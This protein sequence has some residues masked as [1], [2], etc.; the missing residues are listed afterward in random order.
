M[1]VFILIY[2][3][4]IKNR[5][6]F[7]IKDGYKLELQT[8]KTMKFFGSTE[9]D[10]AKIDEIIPSLKAFELVLVQCT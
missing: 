4:K 2:I 10:Q 7:K 8:S 5:L 1:T 6:E 3:N 9:K